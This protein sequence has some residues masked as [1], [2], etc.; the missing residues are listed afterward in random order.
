MPGL[1]SDNVL[2]RLGVA[3]AVV[4]VSLYVFD[5]FGVPGMTLVALIIAAGVL[6]ARER[7]R[8]GDTLD[9]LARKKVSIKQ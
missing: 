6:I 5:S 8:A 3:G 2:I 7:G 9:A 1:D 4:F